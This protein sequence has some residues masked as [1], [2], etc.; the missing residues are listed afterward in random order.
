MT[1]KQHVTQS[2]LQII[3]RN[4]EDLKLL[5]AVLQSQVGK[6]QLAIKEK[7]E[8]EGE[9]TIYCIPKKDL[10]LLALV[11]NSLSFRIESFEYIISPGEIEY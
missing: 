5:Q 4:I 7:G 3:K 1:K 11:A 10:N 8:E 9:L 6:M 2:D